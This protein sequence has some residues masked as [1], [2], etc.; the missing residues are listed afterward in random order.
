MEQRENIGPKHA[1][2]LSDLREWHIITETCFKCGY[3]GRLTACFIRIILAIA[4]TRGVRI[5]R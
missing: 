4:P 5:G 3:Q 1:I 2:R